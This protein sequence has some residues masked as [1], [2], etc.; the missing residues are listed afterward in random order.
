MKTQDQVGNWSS[1]WGRMR[2]SWCLQ[3][4]ELREEPALRGQ[5]SGTSS[6]RDGHRR[7]GLGN[8]TG[9]WCGLKRTPSIGKHCHL[10]VVVGKTEWVFSAPP[11]QKHK[12]GVA[13]SGR[14]HDKNRIAAARSSILQKLCFRK[15]YRGFAGNYTC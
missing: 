15:F 8:V 4:S 3:Q 5:G 12:F 1:L 13:V 9:C 6:R 14:Y 10:N 11:L 2:C 7:R